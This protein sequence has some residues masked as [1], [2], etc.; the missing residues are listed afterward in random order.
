MGSSLAPDVY[1][2]NW[3][4][5]E[6]SGTGAQVFAY[7]IYLNIFILAIHILRRRKTEG[8]NVLWVS[9][10][11]MVVLAT[12]QIIIRL[13]RTAVVI[14]FAG[15]RMDGEPSLTP[16]SPPT[17]YYTL[18]LAQAVI[19][20]LNNLLTD[21]LFLYRCY[22]MW[23]TQWKVVILP[24]ILIIATFVTACVGLPGPYVSQAGELILATITNLCLMI[25]TA[26]RIW[27][28]RR[29]ALRL[30]AHAK[31]IDRYTTV[32]AMI[33]ESGALYFIPAVSIIVVAERDIPFEVLGGLGKYLLNIIPTLIIVR[34]G[35]GRSIQYTVDR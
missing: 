20:T 25:L 30:A 8:N 34:V 10:W 29:E 23:G 5:A 16:S 21:L 14:R 4:V 7:G 19:L 35:L 6:I 3:F 27:W 11:A 15:D 31:L 12:T 22:L 32:I 17:A 33:F 9:T 13:L 18:V 26:G 24:L 1:N 2:Y 28:I